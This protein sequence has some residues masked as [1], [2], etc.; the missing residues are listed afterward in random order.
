MKPQELKPPFPKNERRVLIHDR[1]WYL[2]KQQLAE[3]AFD[4]PGW[5]DASLFGNSNPLQ[6]EY[7]SGNGC[8]IAAQAVANPQINWV[9][10]EL[11]FTRARKIWSK[12]KNLQ[13]NNLIVICGEAYQATKEY[14]PDLCASDIFINFPD[15]W[16]KRRHSKHRLIQ[17]L[18]V[19][20]LARI[21]QGGKS[22]TFVTDG[23]EYSEEVIDVFLSDV[24]FQSYYPEPYFNIEENNYGT[25]YF[26]E[27][28]RAKGKAIRYH[29]FI[30]SRSGI[31]T[32]S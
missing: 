11:K 19:Q 8:W 21:L 7:C 29:R 20:E 27:L 31:V 28:W 25:S 23:P 13:L 14:F 1:V 10:V 22:V 17:P 12:I 24:N 16:P 4:F 5:E 6:I 15:P 32:G 30:K 2:P 18:F 9:A 3:N 26:E